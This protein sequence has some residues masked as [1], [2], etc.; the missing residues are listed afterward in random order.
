MNKSMRI[1]LVHLNVQYKKPE[2]NRITLLRLNREAAL[3]G[4]DIILNTELPISGY[5][6]NSREDISEYLE[7]DRGLTVTGLADIAR[8]HS[9]Y[10]GVGLAERDDA[11]GIFYNSAIAIGPDGRAVCKYR[12]INAE[13]RWAC[14]GDSRQ[15]GTFETPWGRVGILICSDTY[16]G[17]FPRSM[18][19][20]GVDLLWVPANWPPGGIEPEKVWRS[21]VLENGFFLAACNRSGQDRIMDCSE[22]VSCVFDPQGRVLLHESS[23]EST[24]LLVDL[25]LSENG[26]LL[27]MPEHSRLMTRTPARYGPIYLDLRL[28][29]DLTPHYELPQPAPM[30][31]HCVVPEGPSFEL[32]SLERKILEHKGKGPNLFAL[33]PSPASQ[34]DAL[35]G[36]A[37]RGA[38]ALCT[39][40]LGE[41]NGGVPVI[42]TADGECSGGRV[43]LAGRDDEFPFPMMHYGPAKVAMASMDSFVHPELAVVF[44]KLGCDLVV[45]SEERVEADGRLLCQAKSIEGIAVAACASNGALIAMVPRGHEPWEERIMECP[46]VCSY[47]IDIARTRKKRFQ[48]RLNFDLLLRNTAPHGD[49]L[50]PSSFGYGHAGV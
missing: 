41:G 3:K 27:R 14:P 23:K 37:R 1:A 7:T 9:K 43:D 36:L 50:S 47:E 44:S 25:P 49:T 31:V 6:F 32:D 35:H 20:K 8:E 40:L 42:L 11:T 18:A 28:V 33:P 24:V 29:E 39:T 15:K 2:M 48:D 46:G 34:K 12:K 16:Y 38:V 22:A 26:K 10:I 17:L 19:L 4:A 30:Q 5:S 21:R 45:L 13:M